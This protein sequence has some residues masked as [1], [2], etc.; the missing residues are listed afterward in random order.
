MLMLSRMLNPSSFLS[1]EEASDVEGAER[2]EA[3]AEAGAEAVEV[4]A[5]KKE[6]QLFKN[7]SSTLIRCTPCI[8]DPETDRSGIEG[9][10]Y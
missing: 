3:K 1:L 10:G 4:G 9:D 7:M 6:I 5:D 8:R 2:V